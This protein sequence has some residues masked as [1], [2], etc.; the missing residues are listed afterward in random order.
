MEYYE[1][2]RNT[3]EHWISSPSGGGAFRLQ[4]NKRNVDTLCY[5]ESNSSIFRI[6]SEGINFKLVSLCDSSFFVHKF[7][8]SCGGEQNSSLGYMEGH[9]SIDGI[10]KMFVSVVKKIHILKGDNNYEI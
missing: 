8:L 4:K 3:H 5:H 10:F 1:K 2:L 9:F 6:N 7:A